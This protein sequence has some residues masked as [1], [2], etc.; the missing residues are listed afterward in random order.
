MKFAKTTWVLIGILLA[1]L[2]I[3]LLP[4]NYGLPLRLF[5]DEYIQL[6]NALKMMDQKTL[7]LAFSYLPP[8]TSY[9]LMPFIVIYGLVGMVFGQF[10]GL[11]GYK[12]FVLLNSEQLL[13]FTRI[14]SILF[15]TLTVWFLYK[16]GKKLFNPLI[17]V[18]ASL[19]LAFDFLHLH[20]SVSGRFWIPLG[21]FILVA[22]YLLWQLAKTGSKKY[23]YW[24]A[25]FMGLGFG[26]GLLAILLVPWLLLAHAYYLR[27]KNFNQF[28]NKK[29]II[30]LVIL[31][32]IVTFFILGN[33]HSILRQFGRVIAIVLSNF[34]VEFNFEQISNVERSSDIV[35]NIKTILVSLL[36]DLKY[37]LLFAVAGFYFIFKNKIWNWFEKWLFIGFPI[38]YLFSLFFFFS[39]AFHR[40]NIPLIP[41]LLLFA[42]YGLYQVIL[43]FKIKEKK[44]LTYILAVILLI[45]AFYTDAR[46]LQKFT[47]T[48]TR[49]QTLDWI[50]E[51]IPAGSRV[52]IDEE[53]IIHAL[54]KDKKSIEFLRYNNS[55]W[56]NTKDKYLSQLTDENYPK[57]N[58]FIYDWHHL[59]F[60]KLFVEGVRADYYIVSYW[61]KDYLKIPS[62]WERYS[63]L[64]K[65]DKVLIQEFYPSDSLEVI[66][67]IPNSPREVDDTLNNIQ[68][69]GPFV[70]VYRLI[71]KN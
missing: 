17:G 49:I 1:A 29:I 66:Y 71:N 40:F 26:T 55:F 42:A 54:V 36:Y 20:G 31:L 10:A 12:E 63:A 65:F 70:E 15:G 53:D 4:I 46:F 45:P 7:W 30:S 57:P 38:I 3:R 39:K 16:F 61:Q 25:V 48:D 18:V 22:V 69:Y 64:E 35:E 43:K 14:I 2:L 23:Y 44:G 60:D 58:Y 32:V 51:N 56:V 34:G 5:G 24:S 9:L 67:D 62:K 52:I 11:T 27:P 13:I 50:G 19:W 47:V 8:L 59:D 68:G 33:T 41:I 37:L 21:F 6:A 28:F